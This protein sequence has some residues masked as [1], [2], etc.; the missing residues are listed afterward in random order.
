[1][2]S[3]NTPKGKWKDIIKIRFEIYKTE[4][5]K[6]KIISWF[7]WKEKPD[8]QT[9][10]QIK[11]SKGRRFKFNKNRNKRANITSDIWKIQIITTYFK[12][13]QTGK[14]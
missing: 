14:T 3:S 11:Q 4:I 7:F 8:W 12:I 10:S 1:M 5:I 13:Y 6:Y 2:I 9:F